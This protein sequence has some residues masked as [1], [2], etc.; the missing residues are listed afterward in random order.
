MPNRILSTIVCVAFLIGA[1]VTPAMAAAPATQQPVAQRIQFQPG[2]TSAVVQGFAPADGVDRYVLGATAGQT[3]SVMLSSE[4]NQAIL[5]I[6]GADG[7]VL[8]SDH[9]GT[10]EWSGP[11]PITQ[12]YFID[13]RNVGGSPAHYMM[14]VVIPPAPAPE[15]T[16]QRIEFSAG[17]TSATVP[18]QVETGAIGR[19]VLKASAGQT[20]YVTLV[21]TS[22]EAILAI[23]GADGTVLISDHAGTTTWSGP[24]PITQD[25]TIDV[26]NV[27][28]SATA[29]TLQV[30]IP[31]LPGPKPEPNPAAKR[32]Q[33]AR[34]ATSSAVQGNLAVDG[35]NRWVLKAAA[36]Q[37]M[38]VALAPTA[39]Q[40]ILVIWGVDGTVLLSDH[41]G[42][43]SWS[44]RLPKTQDY[45]ID[46]R[47]VGGAATYALRVTIPPAAG[48]A[49]TAKRIQFARGATSAAVK[50]NL[51]AGG[52]NR[53][54]L[55]AGQGQTLYADL[56]F[57]GGPAILVIWGVDGTVLLSDHAGANSWSG[58]LPKTQD[59]IIDVRS[60]GG[61][62]N[63]TLRM[64]IPPK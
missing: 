42:A 13:V 7:T 53:W 32:I 55:K 4:G 44:G 24:L 46:V 5:I 30:A 17:G 3:M 20:I 63:Y 19:Y 14:Q 22:G 21:P 61:A 29:F 62:A 28:Y 27:A 48:P 39:G 40:A 10:A 9:A 36:G 56:T 11:I 8:I 35:T 37:T 41:A 6:W 38:S 31:A 60:I 34:G 18:G 43:T 59:Y 52:A 57:S 50:G 12:D 54:T 49:P 23:Y 51:A 58:P 25:Y 47:A 64:T 2:A 15:P 45:N 26:I 1:L 16:A 33:F